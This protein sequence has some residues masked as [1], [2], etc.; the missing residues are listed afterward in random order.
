MKRILIGKRLI[1]VVLVLGVAAGCATAPEE[2]K[3]P[4]A[5]AEAT[6][7]IEAAKASI[8]EAKSLD[9]VWRDTE[10]FLAK[11]EAAAAEGDS[12]TAIQLANKVHNQAELAVNQYYLEKAKVMFQEAS[13]AEGLSAEQQRAVAGAGEAIRNAEGRKAYDLLAP[14]VSEIQASSMQYQVA[15]GDSLWSI[16]GKQQVYNDPYRWPLIYKSNQGKIRDADLIYPGQLFLVARNP[17]TH[18]VEAAVAHA[19]SRGAWTV[20][21]VEHSDRRYLGGTLQLR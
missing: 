3:A 16:S 2:P 21:V 9:W 12:D 8:A 4:K 19:R 5:S 7:A 18:D 14:L 15:S 17:A 10:D 1:P 6:S 20:G 13:A 11:A